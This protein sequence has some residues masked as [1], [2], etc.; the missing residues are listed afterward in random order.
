MTTPS[1]ALPGRSPEAALRRAALLLGVAGTVVV[2]HGA[3]S[4]PDLANG[5]AFAARLH[6]RAA[7]AAIADLITA[8]EVSHE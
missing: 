3:A 2:C 6:R 8:N 4:G 7:V 1:A 5:I